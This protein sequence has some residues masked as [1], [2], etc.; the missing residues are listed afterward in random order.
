MRLIL[1]GLCTI[2]FTLASLDAQVLIIQ[3][4]EMGFCAVDGQIMTSVPGYTGAGYA[5]TDRGVGKSISWSID[6]ADAGTYTLLWRYANGG[7]S[8]DRPARML[9]NGSTYLDTLNFPHT[10]EWTNWTESDSLKVDLVAGTNQI[11]LEAYSQDG[12]GNYDYFKVVGEGISPADCVPSY[13]VEVAS[14]NPDWG[15]VSYEPVRHYYSEGTEITLEATPNP[16]YFFQSWSGTVPGATAIHTI[17]VTQNISATA[18]FLP[19]GTTA[20]SN[21]IGYATVQDD[22]GTPFLVTGGSLGDTVSASSFEEL[23][24][25]IN[26]PDPM[27]ITLADH[28]IGPAELKVGSSKT[29]LGITENAHLEN[30][31]VEINGVRNVVIRNMKVSHVTP[32]DAVVITGGSKNIWLDH[33][34]LYSDRDHGHDYYDGLLD[35]KNES[36]FI[37]VSWTKFHDHFK[38]S[39]IASG[40]QSVQD[41]VIR[42]TYH[43]NFFFNCGSR[44]PSIRFGRAHIFNNYYRDCETAINS[45]MGACVRVEGNYFEN[46]GTAV[47][48]AYSP[49]PGSVEL[50]DNHFGNSSYSDSPICVLDVP[51][52][53]LDR[54]D[55][56]E[57][58]PEIIAEEI[59]TGI[60]DED[61]SIIPNWTLSNYPNPFN[62]QTRIEFSLKER[63]KVELVIYDIRGRKLTTLLHEKNYSS[64][65]HSLNW[66]ASEIPSGVY[67]CQFRAGKTVLTSKMLLLK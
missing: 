57:D 45:R 30:I 2:F 49:E 42:V 18:I 8:G 65:I 6:A 53:Y 39:L 17:T 21:L 23:Q 35:I 67:L 16:G 32:A 26:D 64:G 28:L 20:D 52:Q 31:E 4:N 63:S 47:M 12:L 25:Y 38:T 24:S 1:I 34:D 19:E 55:D 60:S 3:E 10:G 7:G 22:R 56:T 59:G 29:L 50:I 46:V 62:A 14:S 5:D 15:T 40:D 61:Y 48:M 33:C 9:L 44:L 13:T 58:L 43:H 41:S 36:S 54:L 11:R 37:T 27:V 51:Y 66:D